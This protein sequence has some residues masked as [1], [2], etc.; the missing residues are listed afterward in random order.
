MIK[1]GPQPGGILKYFEEL[2]PSKTI[3][4]DGSSSYAGKQDTNKEFGPK[5]IFEITSIVY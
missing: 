1:G 4:S 2:R 3:R 5:D